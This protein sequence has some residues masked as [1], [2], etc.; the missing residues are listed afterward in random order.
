[1]FFSYLNVH[2][3]IVM[4]SWSR[5]SGTKFQNYYRVSSFSQNN[6]IHLPLT[7]IRTRFFMIA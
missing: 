3:L 5:Q 6:D 1:M 4:V 2:F 7:I